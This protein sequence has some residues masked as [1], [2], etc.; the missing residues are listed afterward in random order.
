MGNCSSREETGAGNE[1]MACHVIGQDAKSSQMSIGHRRVTEKRRVGW[2]ALQGPV[3]GFG[4]MNSEKAQ[5]VSNH[6]SPCSATQ[7][8]DTREQ[9]GGFRREEGG[10]M[11]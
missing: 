6:E 5:N 2:V 10:G 1:G 11:G 7:T 8:M 4:K 9:T 3:R